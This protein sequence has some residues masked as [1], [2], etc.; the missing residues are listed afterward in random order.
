MARQYLRIITYVLAAALLLPLAAHLLQA[1]TRAEL[2]KKSNIVFVGTVTQ[3]G[4]ASF[5]G[6]PASARN[7]VVRVNEVIQKPDDVSLSQGD[8]V[9]VEAKDVSAFRQGTQATFFTDGWIFGEGVAV[10]EVGHEIAP[11][12][13][14]ATTLAAHR[15]EI[16]KTRKEVSDADLRE[17]IQAASVVIVGR[18]TAIRP[19]TMAAGAPGPPAIVTEHDPEWQEAVVHV[20]SAIKGSEANKEVI[21]RFPASQDV[22]WHDVPKLKQGQVGTFLLQKDQI[23]GMAKTMLAGAEVEAYVA[24]ETR[25]VLPASEAERVRTLA[26]RP[27]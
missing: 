19:A 17:R 1:Q 18:V 21:V 8:L 11:A 24:P 13:M 27:R 2:L 23:T 10:R 9:T 5:V 12:A 15:E 6:V 20:E 4:A 14:E 7:V 22:A 25:D 3:V 16:Q 26:Q